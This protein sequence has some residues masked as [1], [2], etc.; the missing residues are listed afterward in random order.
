[1][2]AVASR[3]WT[4]APKCV[5]ADEKDL[6]LKGF[7]TFLDAPKADAAA[8]L[9]QLKVLGIQVKIVTGDNV[10]VAE[11][12]CRS[13]GLEFGEAI[14]GP[15]LDKLTDQELIERIPRTGIFAPRLSRPEVEDHRCPARPEQGRWFPRGRR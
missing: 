14:T 4:G 8:S 3:S 13:L 2:V 1:M 5:L 6:E 15:E 9:A 10:L 12:V 11:S 7:I